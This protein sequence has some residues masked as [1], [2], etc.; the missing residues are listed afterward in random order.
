ML[1]CKFKLS[2]PHQLNYFSYGLWLTFASKF[3]LLGRFDF[4]IPYFCNTFSDHLFEY[5]CFEYICL[6]IYLFDCFNLFL[7]P[8][9]C[10]NSGWT[11]WPKF[12]H[13][14]VEHQENMVIHVS[15]N[16]FWFF[17]VFFPN[18]FPTFWACA[19][20]KYYYN[21]KTQLSQWECPSSLQQV[22]TEQHFTSVGSENTSNVNVGSQPSGF[23]GEGDQSS[24][25]KRCMG[26]GRW[27]VGLVKTWG[28][29]NHCTR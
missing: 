20:H 22:A 12:R 13:I 21:T 3:Q 8:H 4:R 14:H 9:A 27:G 23:L 24:E 25:L 1:S 29:C 15:W 19:G 17:C 11:H 28:Y 6:F 18:Y 5:I 7:C 2:W 10:L 16:M 26:C